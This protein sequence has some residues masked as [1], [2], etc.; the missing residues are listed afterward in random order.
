MA[1]SKSLARVSLIVRSFSYSTSSLLF[2]LVRPIKISRF[3]SLLGRSKN[4]SV[5]K[6]QNAEKIA[7]L[8]YKPLI[9]LVARLNVAL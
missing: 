8:C 1:S 2:S 3:L 7:Y 4:L 5:K 9:S 6:F